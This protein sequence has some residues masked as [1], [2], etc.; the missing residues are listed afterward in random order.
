[1]D[2]WTAKLVGQSFAAEPFMPDGSTSATN[3]CIA[4]NKFGMTTLRVRIAGDAT[5]AVRARTG[6]AGEGRGREGSPRRCGIIHCTD[7]GR[8]MND[9]EQIFLERT[10]LVQARVGGVFLQNDVFE[11]LRV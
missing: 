9:F 7:R 3:H 11:I 1:M 8:L 2:T 10:K 4:T 6:R 5:I